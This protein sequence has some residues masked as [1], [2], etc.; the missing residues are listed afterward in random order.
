MGNNEKGAEESWGADTVLF[1]CQATGFT[2]HVQFVK[3]LSY[4]YTHTDF[5]ISI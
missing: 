4:A 3:F 5:S 1:F 2:G